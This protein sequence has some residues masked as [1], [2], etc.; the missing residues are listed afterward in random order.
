MAFRHSGH[1]WEGRKWQSIPAIVV[2]GNQIEEARPGT[3]ATDGT[4]ASRAH[5]LA[6]PT[7]HHRPDTAGNVRALDA[8]GPPEWLDE[9]AEAMRLSRDPRIVYFIYKGRI[10]SNYAYGGV[11]PYTW[12]EY[13]GA[14]KHETHA[15]VSIRR[16]TVGDDAPFQIELPEQ[17]IRPVPPLTDYEQE[18]IDSL[19]E[20][21]VFT[22]Y[23][24]DEEGEVHA[25]VQL[26]KLAVF[27]MRITDKQEKAD[28]ALEAAIAAL[29]D[30]PC[31][32]SVEVFVN[33]E[34]L[35]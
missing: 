26:K 14:N 35:V 34:K 25:E 7:S 5:D 4:V 18:A 2:L 21:G 6:S 23:T 32:V 3:Y 27:L 16:D 22:E 31:P 33:G 17:E 19:L 13:I 11:E 12:R 30:Q 1:N 24:V 9:Y 28:A 20:D 8:G 15:H 29:A 10:F